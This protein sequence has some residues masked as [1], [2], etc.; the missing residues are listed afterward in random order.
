MTIGSDICD[1]PAHK[2]YSDGSPVAW[3]VAAPSL[4]LSMFYGLILHLAV[5]TTTAG[6]LSAVAA[7]LVSIS[8]QAVG[9]P[10][11]YG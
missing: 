1:T 9:L 6:W 3:R 4:L 5:C 7:P 2:M 10:N 8:H 11:Q